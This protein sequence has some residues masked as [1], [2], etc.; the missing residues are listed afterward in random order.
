MTEDRYLGCL[1]GHAV[2]DATGA[3][4]EGLD[5]RLIYSQFGRA[6]EYVANPPVETLCYTDDTQMSI[7]VAEVLVEFGHI[8]EDALATTFGNNYDPDRGYGQGARRLLHAIRDGEDWREFA[9]TLFPGGSYGNGAA[10]RVAPVA[11]RFADDPERM[12]Q[13]ASASAR[14]THTHEIA[15]DSARLMAA[16]VRYALRATSLDPQAFLEHLRDLATTDEFQWQLNTACKLPLEDSY[17]MF[18]T[19]LEAHRSVTTALMCF[20]MNP[21]SYPDTI[22]TAIGRGGDTDTIAAMAGGISGAYLGLD[23]VPQELRHRFERQAKD[24]EYIST[25]ARKLYS[26]SQ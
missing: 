24:L 7:G 2:G 26:A 16:A 11:L 18:G 10:M 25:L 15:I 14:A 8:D 12:M 23:A 4:V 1:V 3:P 9:R 13:E 17:V 21:E 5:A 19:G 6:I 20:A 22:A